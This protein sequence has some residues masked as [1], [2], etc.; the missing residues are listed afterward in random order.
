MSPPR[1]AENKGLPA[2]W[3]LHHGAFYY[4]VPLDQRAQ[5]DGKARFL[6]GHNLAEAHRTWATRLDSPA[7]DVHTIGQLLDRYAAEVIP[8]KKPKTRASNVFAIKRLRPV[9]GAMQLNA[10]KPRMVYQYVDKRVHKVAARREVE[11]LSHAFTK[12][13]E[14]GCIDEHPFKG[15]VRL[16][17]EKPRDRYVDDDEHA[18]LLAVVPTRGKRDGT[19]AI[20]AYIRL[21][22]LIPARRIDLLRLRVADCHDDGIHLT[23]SKTG[24][25]QVFEWT[26]ALAAAIDEA[27]AARPVHISPW[28]FCNGKGACHV[29]PETDEAPGWK[30][31]WARFKKKAGVTFTDH[32]LRAK[33]ASDAESLERARALLAHADA[34]TTDAIYRRRPERLKPTR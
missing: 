25:R 31:M 21:K 15:E 2:R 24:K 33:V 12:A 29:N 7:V 34:R 8:D 28:L 19:L 27:K 6:L 17:G 32:D 11:V 1:R 4:R 22:A 18:R 14:W 13:V 5:W 16:E 9:F 20:Q 10:L 30:S 3:Q 23:N 26:D